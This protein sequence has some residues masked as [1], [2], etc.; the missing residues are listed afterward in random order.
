[1]MKLT[2][3]DNPPCYV[4]TDVSG[5]SILGAW[6]QYKRQKGQD[7]FLKSPTWDGTAISY[8]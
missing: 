7:H 8:T 5:L 3:Q 4:S 1:M 6:M 2:A